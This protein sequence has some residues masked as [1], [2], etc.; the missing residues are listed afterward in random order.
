MTREKI[1]TT[2]ISIT[3]R[4][5]VNTVR[6]IYTYIYN[7]TGQYKRQLFSTTKF[8]YEYK[9]EHLTELIVHVYT[10]TEYTC[11]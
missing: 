4:R 2:R 9:Q 1:Q 7:S 10:N 8:N 11:S 5:I 6:H 3:Q